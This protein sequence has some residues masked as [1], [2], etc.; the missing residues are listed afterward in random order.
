M[1]IFTFL[2][3]KIKLFF[4]KS[5]RKKNRAPYREKILRSSPDF[6]S[7]VS[8]GADGNYF[9]SRR[10]FKDDSSSFT[11]VDDNWEFSWKILNCSPSRRN[12]RDQFSRPL[13]FFTFTPARREKVFLYI[14]SGGLLVMLTRGF[15]FHFM[16]SATTFDCR[17]GKKCLCDANTQ[18]T[19]GRLSKRFA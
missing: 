3:L 4:S 2:H 1:K 18:E 6:Q 19:S 11:C 13:F 9:L 10:K 14:L 17:N 15:C 16:T 12:S 7:R 5:K 8:C